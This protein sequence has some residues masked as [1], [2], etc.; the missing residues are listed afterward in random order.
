MADSH[1]INSKISATYTIWTLVIWTV[2]NIVKYIQLSA[3]SQDSYLVL[4]YF[5]P[6]FYW[7]S[8]VV[9]CSILNQL[10]C[11]KKLIFWFSVLKQIEKN[12]KM[13]KNEFWNPALV[14][15]KAATLILL[16]SE[17]HD[18]GLTADYTPVQGVAGSYRVFYT[19]S[20]SR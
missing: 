20:L 6:V 8:R 16:S 18:L 7:L 3:P 9:W 4:L 10:D 2:T 5:L 12:D 14:F 19:L 15:D 13:K 1:W 17:S 11:W